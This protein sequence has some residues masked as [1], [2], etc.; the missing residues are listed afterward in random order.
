MVVPSRFTQKLLFLEQACVVATMSGEAPE[1]RLL[2]DLIGR[3]LKRCP[4]TLEQRPPLLQSTLM[5]ASTAA[6]WTIPATKLGQYGRA[7]Y[8]H[9]KQRLMELQ[10]QAGTH[11][12]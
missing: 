6:K 8:F 1:K 4:S 11:Q 12:Q 2:C 5:K 7:F 3:S 9:I 10:N